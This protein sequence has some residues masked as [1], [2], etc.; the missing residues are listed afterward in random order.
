MDEPEAASA[1]AHIAQERSEYWSSLAGTTAVLGGCETLELLQFPGSLAH[2]HVGE[3]QLIEV[4]MRGAAIVRHS[5][6]GAARTCQSGF[7]LKIQLE[8]QSITCQDGREA[9]LSPGDFTLCDDTRPCEIHC[10]AANRLLVVRI[11]EHLLRRHVACAERLTAVAMSGAEPTGE[12]LSVFIRQLWARYSRGIDPAVATH[13]THAVLNLIAGAYALVPQAKRGRLSMSEVHRARIRSYIEK[14]LTD[15]NLTPESI[16]E[17]CNIKGRYLRKLYESEHESLTR[18]IL[19]R[20]L[21]ECA[22]AL[23]SEAYRDRNVTDIAFSYGFNSVTHF[24]RVFRERYG[25]TPTEYRLRNSR[26]TETPNAA[27]GLEVESWGRVG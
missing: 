2:A 20:R 12:L 24:G 27:S 7:S 13:I 11:P 10:E 5:R 18:Y 15:H 14:H 8:G 22:S 23:A 17:A 26:S 1:A 6:P 16:A 25:V 9:H 4:A 19:R 21:E 3:F